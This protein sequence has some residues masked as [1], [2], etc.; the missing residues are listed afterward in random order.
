[1]SAERVTAP[2]VLSSLKLLLDSRPRENF[3]E[4]SNFG[5]SV[6]G[7]KWIDPSV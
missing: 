7:Q 1:M 3:V 2:S 5:N 6:K 4:K